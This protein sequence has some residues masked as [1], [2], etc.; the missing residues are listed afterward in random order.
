MWIIGAPFQTTEK[1]DSGALISA[2]AIVVRNCARVRPSLKNKVRWGRVSQS[3]CPEQVP[4][5][6]PGNPCDKP[7]MDL[8]TCF[9]FGGAA[10][11][12]VQ[13]SQ[14]SPRIR[15]FL[16]QFQ[17]LRGEALFGSLRSCEVPLGPE[18]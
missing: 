17:T 15:V 1:R 18:S 12:Q 4:Q 6:R 3:D 5:V 9:G 10:G 16:G 14:F 2:D 11:G 7:F 8:L 13:G